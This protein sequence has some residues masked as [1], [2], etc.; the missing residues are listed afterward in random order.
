VL[1]ATC[2]EL[3]HGDEDER[4][5]VDALVGRGIEARWQVWDDPAA[6]WDELTVIRSTWDYAPRR[7]QFL[8]WAESVPALHNPY[9]AVAWNSD[10]TYLAELA[11]QGIP[12]VPTA[13]VRPGEQVRYPDAAEWVVKPSIGAGSRGVGRV[14][15]RAAA[16]QHVRALHEAGRTAMLQP[17]LAGVDAAGEAALVLFDGRFSHAATKGAMLPPAAVH[18]VEHDELFV[19]ERIDART[20]SEAE[21]RVGE[22]VVET[23][24]AR[25]GAAPL[26]ARIDLL[27]GPDG[28]V[29]VEV[30]ITEPS[31]FLGHDPGA[32]DRFAAAIAGRLVA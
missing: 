11:E 20:A 15:D 22:R 2:A 16:A 17:Y 8:R 27:P 32:A 5:L 6:R 12:T 31:L 3:P 21:R 4:V 25:F 19:A 28:P 1:L 18:A 10:K 26:Y 24:A 13:F 30:E 29:L 14:R 7:E 23:L 9:P